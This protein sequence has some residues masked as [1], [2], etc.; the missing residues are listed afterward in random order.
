MEKIKDRFINDFIYDILHNSVPNEKI[1]FS[2][3]MKELMLSIL[4]FSSDYIFTH[5]EVMKYGKHINNII[6]ELYQ[7]LYDLQ[8]NY[9]L[10]YPKYEK[11][12]LL[13][14]YFGAFIEDK[15]DLYII[16][17]KNSNEVECAKKMVVDF[18][19][20]MTDRFAIT[21]FKEIMIPKPIKNN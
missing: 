16:E 5:E 13:G 19:S 15:E 11:D 21:C 10:D 1:G 9:D 20:G 4:K 3:N 12:S 6:N 18:I 7:Y 8:R 17:R 2:Q 14:K